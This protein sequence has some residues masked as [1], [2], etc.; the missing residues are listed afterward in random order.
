MDSM[1]RIHLFFIAAALFAL[2]ACGGST[3]SSDSAASDVPVTRKDIHSEVNKTVANLEIGGMTCAE[4]CGGKIQKE[5]QALKGVT[6]TK[7]DF[8]ESRQTNIVSVE[9][10]PSQLSEI[11]MIQCVHSIMDGQYKVQSVEVLTYHGLQSEHVQAEPTGSDT[12]GTG[13]MLQIFGLLQLISQM[14]Q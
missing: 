8:E 11:E 2:A 4:G 6:T 7:L 1:R 14:V 10:D 12:F 9:F 3:P 5:L 13:K